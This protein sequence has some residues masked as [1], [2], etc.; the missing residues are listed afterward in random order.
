VERE[1]IRKRKRGEDLGEKREGN[2][3]TL[4]SYPSAKEGK[5][6]RGIMGGKEGGGGGH[7]PY[8]VILIFARGMWKRV[9]NLGGRKGGGKKNQV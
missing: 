2:P 9:G 7:P 8:F 3:I 4:F 5:K 6:K 1:L